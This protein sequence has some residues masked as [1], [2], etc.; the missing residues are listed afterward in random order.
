MGL[1]IKLISSKI[2]LDPTSEVKLITLFFNTFFSITYANTSNYIIL[3]IYKKKF[4]RNK[5]S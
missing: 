4:Y 2:T 3:H 1:K 5:N